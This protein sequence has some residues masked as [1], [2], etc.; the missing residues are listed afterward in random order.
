VIPFQLHRR[1]PL[2][3]RPFFQRDL[4]RRERDELAARLGKWSREMTELP[5]APH[6]VTGAPPAGEDAALCARIITAYR[7]AVAG[8]DAPTSSFWDHD[9][10]ARKAD[11][12][13][14]LLA[15][16]PAAA[17]A[18]LRDPGRTDLCYGF[19]N[20]ARGISPS[21]DHGRVVYLCLLSL[22]EAIGARP[23]WNPEHP[24]PVELPDLETLLRGIDEVFGFRVDFPNPFAGE[25]GLL[26][27]RGIASYRAV[28]ALCQAWRIAGLVRIKNARILEIGAG[29]GRNAYYA[30]QFGLRD[31]TLVDLPMTNV[32]QANF[33]GRV[34]GGM[35]LF[36]E[37]AA[38]GMRI[39]PPA[40]FFASDERYDLVVNVD[41]LTE[42]S[43]D[44]ALRYCRHIKAQADLFLSINH[45]ACPLPVRAAAAAAG[46]KA[47]GRAPYWLRP[48][49]VDEL[50]IP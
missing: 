2:I 16:D 40:A 4:A 19:D 30:R 48:G 43:A 24:M 18:M 23:A 10:A 46:M 38:G 13:A 7:L 42:L 28:Q 14:A 47:A 33:L 17:M 34:A 44:T 49:Y 50:F 25:I 21:G 5:A 41:S 36:G 12:H 6:A 15:D 37:P 39:L 45:E 27:S 32:A 9:F 1:L 20:L 8:A 26:T 35:T 22:S 11:I 29:M 3:R 31:Y